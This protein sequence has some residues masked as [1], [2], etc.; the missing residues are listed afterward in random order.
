[1]EKLSLEN[2]ELFGKMLI[3]LDKHIKQLAEK[4]VNENFEK[5]D[6]TLKLTVETFEQVDEVTGEMCKSPMFHFKVCSTLQQKNQ[7]LGK[8]PCQDKALED[9]CGEIYLIDIN[10][11]QVSIDDLR[12]KDYD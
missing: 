12:G 9:M 3:D 10:K 2:H 5:G 1:M 11:A 7:T 4:L 8:L 6:I